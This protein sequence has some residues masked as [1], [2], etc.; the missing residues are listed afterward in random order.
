[1]HINSLDCSV[2]LFQL[3]D[4]VE[5]GDSDDERTA[6]AI[7]T[8]FIKLCQYMEGVLSLSSMP[9]SSSP[10]AQI[11]L[12]DST[13]RHWL[14]N[15]DPAAR[16]G[17]TSGANSEQDSI[18]TVYRALL[19]LIFKSVL[20]IPS[21]IR[22]LIDPYIGSVVLIR[23]RHFGSTLEENCAISPRAPSLETQSVAADSVE[24]M[25]DLIERDLV[26]LCPTQSVTAAIPPLIIQISL[27]R[28]H[29]D[30]DEYR[31]AARRFQTCMEFLRQLGE[32]YWHADF[33]REYFGLAELNS[34]SNM[35][36]DLDIPRPRPDP[37]IDASQKRAPTYSP[38]FNYLMGGTGIAQHGTQLIDNGHVQDGESSRGDS[39]YTAGTPL[40]AP[41]FQVLGDMTLAPGFLQSE[42]STQG[43]GNRLFED[44]LNN[45]DMFQSLFPSA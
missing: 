30:G 6:K 15:L 26:R 12:C 7:F 27:M 18:S 14:G 42:A 41:S 19:H 37:S 13:L 3:S 9:K 28:C 4:L 23:L 44:L 38:A 16:R 25:T 22:L 31:K 17:H 32:N 29:H 1:M 36:L 11:S 20:F 39:S 33:Y 43:L 2:P 45:Y 35:R 10:E 5:E 34:R 8:E 40:A 24:L 21:D